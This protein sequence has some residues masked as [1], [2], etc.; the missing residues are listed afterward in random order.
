MCCC[1]CNI[2]KLII[3]FIVF[4]RLRNFVSSFFCVE[5]WI[6]LS[7]EC[8]EIYFPRIILRPAPMFCPACEAPLLLPAWSPM[9]VLPA[10]KVSSENS[11]LFSSDGFGP[12]CGPG[13]SG[14]LWHYN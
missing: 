8:S 4:P 7:I 14:C 11:R 12:N 10:A 6:M 2:K 9:T 3:E 13:N 5:W 1:V